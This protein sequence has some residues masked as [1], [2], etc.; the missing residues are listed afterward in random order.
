LISQSRVGPTPSA[1][2]LGAVCTDADFNPSLCVF[3]YARII[4]IPTPR[5]TDY[6]RVK[7][8]LVLPPEIPLKTQELAYT[9]PI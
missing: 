3:Y 9:S 2:E 8:N 7:F 4:E 6:D 1:P 5:W